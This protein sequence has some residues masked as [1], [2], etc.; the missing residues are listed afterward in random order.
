MEKKF[1]GVQSVQRVAMP[2]PLNAVCVGMV[3]ALLLEVLK[4]RL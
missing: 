4:V 1:S 3:Q 2:F